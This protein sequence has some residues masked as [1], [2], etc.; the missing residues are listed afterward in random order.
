MHITFVT[1]VAQLK[2]SSLCTYDEKPIILED[3]WPKFVNDVINFRKLFV[4]CEPEISKREFTV[5]TG[6][7]Y[8]HL[9]LFPARWL[10][11]WLLWQK[12]NELL[13]TL[14]SCIGTSG[15]FTE[16]NALRYMLVMLAKLELKD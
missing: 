13:S 5:H 3:E 2:L 1:L 8:V 12:S 9:M 10:Y 7:E 15:S 14:L 16:E 4:N 6:R 11:V